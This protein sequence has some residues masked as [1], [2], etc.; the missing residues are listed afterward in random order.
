MSESEKRTVVIPPEPHMFS[1]SKCRAFHVEG[2]SVLYVTGA[3]DELQIPGMKSV[4][5]HDYFADLL[6]RQASQEL[7]EYLDSHMEDFSMYEKES[8]WQHALR[9]AGHVII[10]DHAFIFAH[11]VEQGI[12]NISVTSSYEYRDRYHCT[13][14]L[15]DK[16]FTI[17]RNWRDTRPM[18]ALEYYYGYY[19]LEEQIL[20]QQQYDAG[21]IPAPYMETYLEI[22]RINAWLGDKHSVHCMF[23]NGR[24]TQSYYIKVLTLHELVRLK[25]GAF[26]PYTGNYRYTPFEDAGIPL[27]FSHYSNELDVNLEAFAPIVRNP[28]GCEGENVRDREN[29]LQTVAD[30]L[31]GSARYAYYGVRFSCGDG[32]NQLEFYT[33]QNCTSVETLFHVEDALNYL[34][35]NC[36]EENLRAEVTLYLLGEGDGKPQPI[37][38]SVFL[39]MQDLAVWEWSELPGFTLCEPINIRFDYRLLYDKLSGKNLLEQETELALKRRIILASVPEGKAYRFSYVTAYCDSHMRTFLFGGHIQCVN[40]TWKLNPLGYIARAYPKAEQVTVESVCYT[41]GRGAPAE[42]PEDVLCLISEY[43]LGE[44]AKEPS[45]SFQHAYGFNVP[46]EKLRNCTQSPD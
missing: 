25:D 9:C 42:M 37:P 21:M 34:L 12:V 24:K 30:M 46:A 39:A 29:R 27:R 5:A 44:F 32:E 35:D 45:V 3:H 26:I 18:T 38:E 8:F 17:T 14:N 13:Y 22:S 11:H 40:D 16:A 10:P 23:R 4:Y 31:R 1:L 7:G 36:A 28:D 41:F 20:A 2:E 15:Y 43:G 33:S 19:G 6:V